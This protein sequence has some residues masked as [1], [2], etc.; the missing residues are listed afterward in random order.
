MDEKKIRNP[1]NIVGVS[2]GT[3]VD[4]HQK[5]RI[6]MQELGI[7]SFSEYVKQLIKYDL[8]LP[9]Y[10]GQYIANGANHIPSDKIESLER[11]KAKAKRQRKENA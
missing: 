9:N 5:A 3:Q 8:G 10:I 6:R 4:L 2:F 1:K 7:E 11:A